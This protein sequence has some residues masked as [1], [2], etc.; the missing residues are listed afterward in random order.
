M[1]TI[2]KGANRTL[3]AAYEATYGTKMT[4]GYHTLYFNENSLGT[5]NS[6]VDTNTIVGNRYDT[7]PVTGLRDV[8][9]SIAVPV[10]EEA[11]G[12]WLNALF[13][14]LSTTGSGTYTHIFQPGTAAR[15]LSIENGYTDISKYYPFTGVKVNTMSLDFTP[16]NEVVASME[17]VGKDELAAASSTIDATPATYVLEKYQV[18]NLTIS[19]DSVALDVATSCSLSISNNLETDIYALNGGGYREFLPEGSFS[20]EGSFSMLFDDTDGIAVYAAALAG[21]EVELTIALTGTGSNTLTFQMD[22]ILLPQISPSPSGQGPVTL[23]VPFQVF[24]QNGSEGVPLEVTM[25][26]TTATY[27]S[28]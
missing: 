4:D 17:C 5:S 25:V 14:S 22:E 8:S 18:N 13:G 2:A 10:D 28:A 16:G 19:K 15:S 12:F 7:K 9:G 3:K 20:I 1:A 21:T 27:V 26:N 6:L 23:D 24:Y 11:F